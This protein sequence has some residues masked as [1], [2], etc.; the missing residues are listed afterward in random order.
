MPTTFE[1]ILPPT[2][3]SPHASIRWTPAAAGR[4]CL[5]VNTRRDSATYGVAEFPAHGGRGFRLTKIAGG[6]LRYEF[7]RVRDLCD[8]FR[9][10]DVVGG[11]SFEP[12]FGFLMNFLI[13]LS[14]IEDSINHL[15]APRRRTTDQFLDEVNALAGDRR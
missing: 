7:D 15:P 13:E 1:E 6:N 3:S 2:T 11:P 12:G 9:T 5:I 10:E 14:H 4:G 8:T